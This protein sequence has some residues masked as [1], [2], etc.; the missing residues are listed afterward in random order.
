VQG[1]TLGVDHQVPRRCYDDGTG[2]TIRKT[3]LRC[4]QSGLSGRLLR[5]SEASFWAR[6]EAMCAVRRTRSRRRGRDS[7][8][9]LFIAGDN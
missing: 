1:P 2:P 8:S 6:W 4:C 9:S 3:S 7:A 5:R